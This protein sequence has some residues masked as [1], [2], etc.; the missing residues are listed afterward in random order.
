MSWSSCFH[1]PI[2]LP[3]GARLATLADAL[4]YIQSLP[5]ELQKEDRWQ[6]GRWHRSSGSRR[7]STA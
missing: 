5:E 1:E 7:K 4:A 3:N 6:L 2:T